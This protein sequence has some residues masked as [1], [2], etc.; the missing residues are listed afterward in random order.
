MGLQVVGFDLSKDLL[1]EARKLAEPPEIHWVRG[2]M[3]QL[4]FRDGAFGLVVNFFTAFGYFQEERENA[5]VLSEV[6]R[7]LKPNGVFLLDFLNKS[8]VLKDFAGRK[9]FS[10]SVSL[11]DGTSAKVIKA[12]VGDR[13]EKLTLWKDG[14]PRL[15]ESLRLYGPGELTSLMEGAGLAV[16][17]C[18]GDY[19]ATPFREE[20]SPRFIAI[21]RS[22]A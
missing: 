16:E 19:D 7:V 20:K 9:E 11:S 14:G 22:A 18:H 21:A 13:V 2:D 4:P 1:I 17:S 3:R 6:Q 5:H 8:Q 10:D 15:R 12:L